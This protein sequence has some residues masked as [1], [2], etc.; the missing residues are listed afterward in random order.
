MINIPQI[1]AVEYLNTAP[2]LFGLQG[3]P[4]F[5]EMELITGTPAFC[6]EMLLQKEA[7]I[8]LIPVGSLSDFKQAHIISD[9]CI[10]CNG[11][12][13]TVGIWSNRELDEIRSIKLDAA[14]RTSNLLAGNIVRQFWKKDIIF[15]EA[16]ADAEVVI[17]DRTFTLKDKYKFMWDLGSEWKHFTN[18]PFVFAVWASLQ[19][20]SLGFLKEFNEALGNGIQNLHQWSY[21]TNLDHSTLMKYLGHSISFPLDDLKKKALHQFLRMNQIH[22]QLYF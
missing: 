1:V 15:T 13:E 16:N 2:M 19:P 9:Y 21:Q 22:T 20:V 10:G 14:S 4:H 18:L 8:A 12:V 7:C 3:H 6:A 11:A 5:K 17:G